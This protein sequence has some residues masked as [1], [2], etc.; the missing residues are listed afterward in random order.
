MIAG[1][2]IVAALIAVACI[3]STLPDRVDAAAGV[4]PPGGETA[5]TPPETAPTAR[6]AVDPRRTTFGVSRAS[7]EGSLASGEVAP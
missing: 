7:A 4:I 5:Y 3:L 6:T 2:L 1:I